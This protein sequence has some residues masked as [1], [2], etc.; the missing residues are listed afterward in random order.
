MGAKPGKRPSGGSSGSLFPAQQNSVD[1]DA[2]VLSNMS[3]A[4]FTFGICDNETRGEGNEAGDIYQSAR[5]SQLLLED[6]VAL[7]L[8][9]VIALLQNSGSTHGRAGT[10]EGGGA[11]G[12]SMGGSG[13]TSGGGGTGKMAIIKKILIIIIVIIIIIIIIIIYPSFLEYC[14]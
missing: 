14:S 9:S 11:A 3:D 5:E 8:D 1:Y 7:F 12:G 10:A 2:K 6:W 4:T 13:D